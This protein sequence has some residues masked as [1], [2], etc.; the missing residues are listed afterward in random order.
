MLVLLTLHYVVCDTEN[1]DE[2]VDLSRTFQRFPSADIRERPCQHRRQEGVCRRRSECR[3][4]SRSTCRFGLNP[5][6]CCLDK[7]EPPTTT[8]TRRPSKPTRPSLDNV[9]E[10]DLTFPN[11]GLRSPK[12]PDDSRGA[13]ARSTASSSRRGVL[14][15]LGKRDVQSHSRVKRLFDVARPIIV[16]GNNAKPN[17]WPWMVALFKTSV[18]G[19]P[20]RF[21][22]GASLISRQYVVTAAHCFDSERGNIDATQF[23][24]VVGSHTTK[25]GTEYLVENLLIH[26]GYQPRQYY[27]DLCLMKIDGLVKLTNNTYPVC[28]PS[29][30]LRDKIIPGEKDATVTGWGDTTFEPLTNEQ[31]DILIAPDSPDFHTTLT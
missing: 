23:S 31:N 5:I 30:G 2:E 27:N 18:P 3:K 17:S 16:G 20:K 14:S 9:R 26:P 7:P 8:T 12:L 6:V 28:L 11:C 22:C 4:P 25:D 15:R 19:G 1:A 21:L 24:I 10:I 29:D 13:G